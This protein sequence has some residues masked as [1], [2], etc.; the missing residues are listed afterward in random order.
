L[1]FYDFSLAFGGYTWA[2]AL[3]RLD[4][5]LFE[6]NGEL[7]TLPDTVGELDFDFRREKRRLKLRKIRF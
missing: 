2:F 6:G 7:S 1:G 4:L 5:R 3:D